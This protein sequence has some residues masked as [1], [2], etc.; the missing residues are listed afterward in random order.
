MHFA[1]P[2]IVQAPTADAAKD[3]VAKGAPAGSFVGDPST[4]SFDSH[5]KRLL[6]FSIEDDGFERLVAEGR[7]IRQRDNII[8]P[9]GIW[10]DEQYARLAISR[11]VSPVV[12]PEGQR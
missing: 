8:Y 12:N 11:A 4:A 10:S 2:V 9:P 5:T 6:V 7:A 1:T 3:A